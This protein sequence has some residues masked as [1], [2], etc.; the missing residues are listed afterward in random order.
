[1]ANASIKEIKERIKSIQSTMQITRAM[2][3]VATSKLRAAKEQMEVVRPFYE[4]LLETIDDIRRSFSGEFD[5]YMKKRPSGRALYIAISGDRGLAGGYNHNLSRA[6]A[7]H[8]RGRDFCIF[9]IGK[10]SHEYCAGQSFEI[11]C[12]DY[13]VAADVSIAD[14]VAMGKNVFKG[15]ENGE[16]TEIFIAYTRFISVLSQEPE[17]KQILPVLPKNDE[18]EKSR[19]ITICEP[20]AEAVFKSI[21]PQYISGALYGAISESL[22]SELAARRTAM[23]AANKNAKEMIDDL[24]LKYNRSRQ[25]MITQELTEIVS[26]AEAL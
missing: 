26:G 21:V 10:K 23:S 9:P 5:R 8:S 2:E 14:C 3:L 6:L 1:M 4:I 20:S 15:F 12:K 22:A 13:Q 17:I 18:T 16:Y 19:Q 24:R 7:E 25:S 11:Y